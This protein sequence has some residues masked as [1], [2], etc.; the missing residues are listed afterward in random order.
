MKPI[1]LMFLMVCIIGLIIIISLSSCSTDPAYSGL[2][3]IPDY[4]YIAPNI[5][6]K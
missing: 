6:S 5:E 4:V 2:R 1:Y 3:I